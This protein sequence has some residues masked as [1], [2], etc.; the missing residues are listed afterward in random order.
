MATDNQSPSYLAERERVRAWLQRHPDG[1]E[2]LRVMRQHAAPGVMNAV[3]EDDDQTDWEEMVRDFAGAS[4]LAASNREAR[5]AF[6]LARQSRS[7]LGPPKTDKQKWVRFFSAPIGY[8]LRRQIEVCDPD[9]WNQ[10]VNV[11]REALAHP[12]WAT[13]PPD[14][15]RG[16]LESFLPRGQKV[17]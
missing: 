7:T 9:Y 15:I 16:A 12:E 2:A 1:R 17:A 5:E 14:Y 11:Y 13:A 3:L 4:V 6:E 10:P 8:V